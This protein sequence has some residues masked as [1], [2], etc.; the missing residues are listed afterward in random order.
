MK[1][2][3]NIDIH[4]FRGKDWFCINS[5][6]HDVHG[7]GEGKEQNDRIEQSRVEDDGV[8]KEKRK[9]ERQG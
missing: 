4:K 8:I 1:L 7:D 9:G 3:S 2:A 5:L 6:Y